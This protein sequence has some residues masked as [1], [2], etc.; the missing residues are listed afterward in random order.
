MPGVTHAQARRRRARLR[1]RRGQ[2]GGARAAGREARAAD[3]GRGVRRPTRR[4]TT[5]AARTARSAVAP[6]TGARRW[7][8][9]STVRDHPR[10]RPARPTAGSPCRASRR[11][12][13]RTGMKLA[14]LA[15]EHEGKLITFADTQARPVPVITSPEWSGSE[16]GG[17]RYSPFTVNVERLKPWHTLTGPPALLPRPRLDD[18][19]RRADAGV[20]AAAGHARAVRR[21]APR[22]DRRAG[23]D[24]ALPDPA[25]QVVDPLGVPGQPVH[26]V[27]LARRARTSG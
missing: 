5:C 25:Q 17:R 22:G 8:A 14:D 3:Q 15:A 18:R 21:A 13:E 10:A 7:P 19:A 9:T 2:V 4:S 12:E 27:A 11:L 16:H 24:A 23:A 6:R 20:P 1:R 26:A